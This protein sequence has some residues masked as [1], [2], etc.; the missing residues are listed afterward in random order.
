M[1][2]IYTLLHVSVLPGKNLHGMSYGVSTAVEKQ[3]DMAAS[4][5]LRQPK[6][7]AHLELVLCSGDRGSCDWLLVVWTGGFWFLWQS[8]VF[9]SFSL[10]RL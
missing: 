5:D 7:D 10:P 6:Q 2:A 3:T 8:L 9:C 1:E 4:H